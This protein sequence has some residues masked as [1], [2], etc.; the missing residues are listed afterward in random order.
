MKNSLTL[1]KIRELIDTEEYHKMG[2]KTTICLLTLENG[3]EVVGYSS[4]VDPSNFDE[5]IGRQI[6]KDNA[7]NKVWELEGYKL[8]YDLNTV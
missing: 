4:C 2:K 3:F 8:Q 5:I 6:A 1:E 7:V